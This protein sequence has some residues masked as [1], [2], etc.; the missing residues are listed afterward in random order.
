MLDKTLA[1]TGLVLALCTTRAGAQLSQTWGP[2]VAP[3]GCPVVFTL[4]NDGP[5]D[6]L[7]DS[8][9]WSVYDPSGAV[10]ASPPCAGPVLVPVGDTYTWTWDQNDASGQQVPAGIYLLGAPGGP[11]VP[12][13]S[14]PFAT[15]A[16]LGAPKLGTARSLQLCSTQDP[17]FPYLLMA[18]GSAQVGFATCAGP[19]PLDVDPILAASLFDPGT[20]QSFFGLLDANG[21]S[22]APTLALPA[23]PQLA[24][25]QLTLAFAVLDFAALPCPIRRISATLTLELF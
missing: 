10:V 9:A 18:S 12:V 21:L 17:S 20:F 15:I 1:L 5:V 14:A 13:S 7:I 16:P 6:A 8:C 25:T 24:G 11:G 3:A 2:P 23:A 19:F 22:T 4:S